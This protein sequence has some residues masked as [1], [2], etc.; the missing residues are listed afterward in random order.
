[1]QGKATQRESTLR[2]LER[3]LTLKLRDK[4]EQE[5]FVTIEVFSLEKFVGDAAKRALD[6]CNTH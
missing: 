6:R 5:I 1:M 4:V 2:C 3:L